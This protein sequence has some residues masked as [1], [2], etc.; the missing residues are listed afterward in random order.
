MA[1]LTSEECDFVAE[2]LNIMGGPMGGPE[3]KKHRAKVDLLR[4]K[5]KAAG[6]AAHNEVC[7]TRRRSACG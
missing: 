1:T 3:A 2:W 7:A 5:L 6:Q 4:N